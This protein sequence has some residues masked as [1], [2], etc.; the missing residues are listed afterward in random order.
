MKWCFVAVILIVGC[1]SVAQH[2]DHIMRIEFSSLTRGYQEHIV[3]TS[4]S[5]KYS[6]VQAGHPK[7]ARSHAIKKSEWEDLLKIVQKIDLKEM[8]ELKSPTM[9]RSF[10]GARHSTISVITDSNQTF[11][12]LFDDENPHEKLKALMSAIVK[13][14]EK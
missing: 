10:D 6:R 13:K 4:D 3:I 2:S 5:V 14:R 7:V 12:H 8:S 11:R 1:A 9:K